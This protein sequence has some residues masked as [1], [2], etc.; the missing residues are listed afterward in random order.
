MQKVCSCKCQVRTKVWA[1]SSLH[2]KTGLSI[3]YDGWGKCKEK[4]P[5]CQI[6]IKMFKQHAIPI[7]NLHNLKIYSS[8]ACRK[9]SHRW[10]ICMYLAI[11]AVLNIQI[12]SRRYHFR[13]W[14]FNSTGQ[15]YWNWLVLPSLIQ[16]K[17]CQDLW[18]PYILF[19]PANHVY[20]ACRL[21]HITGAFEI[22]LI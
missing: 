15:Y 8:K 5:M 20:I 22:I 9:T 21:A 11:T 14:V 10:I 17:W 2:F 18:K 7:S 4:V 13:L 3:S 1:S 12:F 19:T 16:S 6:R